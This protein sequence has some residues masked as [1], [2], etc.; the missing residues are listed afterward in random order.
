MLVEVR[1]IGGRSLLRRIRTD[2]RQ[3]HHR[4]LIDPDGL[5]G[6]DFSGDNVG[7]DASRLSGHKKPKTY[8]PEYDQRRK[9]HNQRFM[10]LS[11]ALPL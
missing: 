2:R 6:L 3:G 5:S 9:T 4:D 11:T 1:A 7:Q 8:Q 10:S